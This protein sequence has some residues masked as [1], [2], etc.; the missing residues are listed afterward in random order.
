MKSTN[1]GPDSEI[2]IGT[3][4]KNKSCQV[5]YEGTSSNETECL[6]HPGVPVFHEGLKYW[7]CCQRK[8]TEFDKFLEQQGC[9]TGK[10]NWVA[11]KET[12]QR[13]NCRMDWHQTGSNVTI[14]VFA[15]CA[16]PTKTIVKVNQVS[17]DIFIVYEDD[18][19]YSQWLELNGIIDIGKSCVKLLGSKVEIILKKAEP[20]SWGKLQ[21][22]SQAGD[23]SQSS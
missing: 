8:T 11:V 3:A 17:V 16:D 9:E 18:K 7:S 15:K 12:V 1:N 19:I 2:E 21:Y 22:E 20:V 4:C 13:N 14:S 10:H 5:R 6:Y 23:H